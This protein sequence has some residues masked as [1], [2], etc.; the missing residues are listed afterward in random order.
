MLYGL[1]LAGG[2][3]SRM[4]EDK[5]QLVFEGTTLI[6]R[7]MQLLKNTG[8]DN[9]LVSGDIEGID[10]IPDILKECGP[11]GGLHASLHFIEQSV[12]FNDDLLLIIPVDMPLLDT[13]TLQALTE[14]IEAHD[15]CHYTNEIFPCVFR[16][17]A[18]L[19]NH[20]DDLF[21]D[22]RTLGGERSMKAL[23]NTFSERVVSTEGL[24]EN[25]FLN[26]NRPEDWE[27]FLDLQD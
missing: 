26:I 1:L 13:G 6:Q 20:L 7:A 8:A 5:R 11:L 23:L 15:V 16:L 25:A 24:S 22:D 27:L 9:V 2:K 19:K 3:S 12:S 18:A 10:S 17:S 4:G 14:A 21:A